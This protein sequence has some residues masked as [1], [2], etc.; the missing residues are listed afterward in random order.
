MP[1]YLFLV[2]LLTSCVRTE[3]RFVPVP[4]APIPVSLLADCAVPLIPDPLTWGESLELNEQL[5]T[6]VENCN[7]DKAAIREIEQHRAAN[8]IHKS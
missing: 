5:L 7:N 1:L 4:P 6:T 8:T 2:A 3:T